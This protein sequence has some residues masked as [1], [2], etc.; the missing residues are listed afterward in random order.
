MNK[1][2]LFFILFF[3]VFPISSAFGITPAQKILGYEPGTEQTFS[4][5]IINS[6]NKRVNLVI[7]PEGELSQSVALSQYYVT[8]T[9]E[10]PSVTIKY[11]VK[12]PSG[13]SPGAHYADIVVTEV[14]DTSSSSSPTYIGSIVGIAT[15]ILVDVPYP[16]KYAESALSVSTTNSGKIAFVMPLV[17]KGKLDIVRARAVIDIYTPLNEK[18][19][20]LSTQ[21]IEVLSGERKELAVEWDTTSI[22]FGRYR[23]FATVLYDESTL[24]LEKEFSVGKDSLELKSVEVN[25]FS[26][27][28]IAKFEF[29]VENS[30][31]SPIED[32][33]ISM[34]VF[35]QD[36]EIMADFKSATYKI[37]SFSSKL[38]VS[39]WDTEGVRV[40]NYD[41]KAFINFGQSSIQ[42]DLTLDVSENDISVIGVGYVI[43]SANTKQ[44]DS[45]VTVLIIAVAVLVLLNLTWFLFLRRKI[46]KK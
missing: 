35:N 43:K 39:F 21:E 32:A 37:D 40:G 36:G 17:S 4:F 18:V 5:D 38:L 44:S 45:L 14:P 25:D 34:Q 12:I 23:A 28:E 3:I 11:S 30:L 19:I 1:F 8:L 15:K 24:T 6:E 16:G 20:S 33:Y 2:I 41:A 42:K 10:T 46:K 26:L 22:P 13:L 31:N 9:P 29:L 27:G 7:L